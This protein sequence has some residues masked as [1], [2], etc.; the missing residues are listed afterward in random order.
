MPGANPGHYLV[1]RVEDTGTGI[2]PEVIDRIFEPFFTT[3]DTNRGTGLGLST[4][5]GIVKGHGGF[6]RVYSVL[7]KGSTFAIYLPAASGAPAETTLLT[8]SAGTFRGSGETILVVD[9]E[10]NVRNITR[11]VLVALN[12]KVLTA[13][14]GT[15]ALTQLAEKGTELRAVITDLHM[16]GMDGLSFVRLLRARVPQAGVIVASGRLDPGAANEFTALG[17]SA[18]LSKPFTQQDLVAALRTVF[19]K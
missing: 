12:F 13:S 15:A 17:I 10:V 18:L 16:P 3:K 11:A 9:D 19:P 1:W 14:D 7:R 5:V 6:V 8:N 4:V 2:P